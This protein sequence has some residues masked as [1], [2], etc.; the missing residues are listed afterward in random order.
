AY[1][2]IG[3]ENRVLAAADFRND[4]VDAGDIGA[5]H[6]VTA[7]YEIMPPAAVAALNGLDGLRYA[8]SPP[9]V[10]S[11][12]AAELL[13]VRLRYKNP[14]EETSHEFETPYV[15]AVNQPPSSN[16][17]WSAAVAAFGMLLRHSPHRG[18]A[19]IP[20]ILE[21]ARS[22]VGEDER[23]HRREFIRLVEQAAPYLVQSGSPADRARPAAAAPATLSAEQ[24]QV[25]A[26][27]G[28]K[29]V[30]LLRV[31]EAEGDQATYGELHEFGLWEGREYQG[32]SNLPKGYWVYVAPR[33]YIWGD[34]ADEALSPK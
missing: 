20:L 28:G 33:W 18:D 13:A 15:P 12:R 1:R 29:Y 22:S 19:S 30:N 9:V 14:G 17:H 4:S 21:L 25:V 24:S 32:Q 3:Y 23:G 34:V 31:L 2:L 6:R 7:L 26:S 11:D 16:L 5:G 8:S 10:A 27:R